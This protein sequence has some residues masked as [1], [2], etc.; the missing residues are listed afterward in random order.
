MALSHR[1]SVD[2]LL[3][4]EI[5]PLY[6]G[7]STAYS[8]FL[9]VTTHKPPLKITNHIQDLPS[10]LGAKTRRTELL[11]QPVQLLFR[12]CALQI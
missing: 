6:D 5:L 9:S 8:E 4:L 10:D 11:L 3:P 7:E 2:V 1:G 12:N